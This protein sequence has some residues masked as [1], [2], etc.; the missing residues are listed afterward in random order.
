MFSLQ[1]DKSLTLAISRYLYTSA[2]HALDVTGCKY[3][4]S[5]VTFYDY[6]KARVV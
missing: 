6:T 5:E 3:P 2:K 4:A 1:V